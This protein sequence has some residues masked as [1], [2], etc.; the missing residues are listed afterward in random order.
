MTL[1]R[2]DIPTVLVPQADEDDDETRRLRTADAAFIDAVIR[3]DD[4]AVR[5][6]LA[7]GADINATDATGRSSLACALT[8]PE[9]VPVT[10]L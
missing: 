5:D 10:N 3:A 6:A 1:K 9:Y 8:G 4:R 2:P 7:S